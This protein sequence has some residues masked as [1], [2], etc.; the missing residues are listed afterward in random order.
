MQYKI[1]MMVSGEVTGVQPYGAF[2]SLD[3]HTQGLI[4]ISEC[5]AGYV[6]DIHKHLAVGQVVDVMIIDIDE[7]SQKISLS[8]RCLARN[9][10]FDKEKN[11]PKY[12]HK[13]YWTNRHVQEG[14][15]PI[16]RHMASW[17][18]EALKN[19]E[20]QKKD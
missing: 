13:K 20:A 17:M 9:F 15:A 12:Q 19:L 6:D 1:G 8:I 5:Y 14:F 16:E 10:S 11:R 4:H 7:Y 3:E 18:R 2:V